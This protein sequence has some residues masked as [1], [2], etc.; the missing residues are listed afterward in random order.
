MSGLPNPRSITSMPARRAS[1]FRPSMIVKTYGGRPGDAAE[2]HAARR[3]PGRRGWH[4]RAGVGDHLRRDHRRSTSS[5]R[6]PAAAATSTSTTTS[7]TCSASTGGCSRPPTYPADY[8][9]IPDTLSEDGDPL[10]A[11]VLL[12]EPTFPGCWITARPVGV[13]W[14]EDDDGPDAKIL[15]VPAGD[16]RWEQVD[17]IADLPATWS[18]RSST[19]SR[20]TRCSSPRSTRA[21][22]AGRAPRPPRRDRGLPPAL[23]RRLTRRPAIPAAPSSTRRAPRTASAA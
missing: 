21:S 5:S 1:I 15:C 10:D 17:D 22:G 12:E 20:S 9:F 19:S 6:S 8:G 16:P 13:F 18:T 11:L 4:R 7:R 14:M 2:L 23:H 3:Y